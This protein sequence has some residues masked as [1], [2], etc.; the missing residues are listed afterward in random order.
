MFWWT[1]YVLR[2][3]ACCELILSCIDTKDRCLTENDCFCVFV[4]FTQ[5]VESW[6]TEEDKEELSW[7]FSPPTVEHHCFSCNFKYL[8]ISPSC[9]LPSYCTSSVSLHL[10]KKQCLFFYNYSFSMSGEKRIKEWCIQNKTHTSIFMFNSNA[11]WSETLL[12]TL[13]RLGL[14]WQ[15]LRRAHTVRCYCN[16]IAARRE[17]WT[18]NIRVYMMFSCFTRSGTSNLSS[19]FYFGNYNFI[20]PVNIIIILSFPSML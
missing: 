2:T 15:D 18:V 1:N 3:S 11:I 6:R 20:M 4:F 17:G 8:S 10:E 5:M 19:L 16:I 7:F 14:P 9:W 13:T 12:Q